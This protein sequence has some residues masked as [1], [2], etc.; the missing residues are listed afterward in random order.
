MTEIGFPI[1]G[2]RH[3]LWLGAH[4]SLTVLAILAVAA[5]NGQTAFG[6]SASLDET[7]SRLDRTLIAQITQKSPTPNF[8]PTTPLAAIYRPSDELDLFGVGLDGAVNRARWDGRWHEWSPVFRGK[9]AQNTPIA[10]V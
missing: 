1:G 10:A 9:L 6:G 4:R 2:C 3:G 7:G 5:A 8:S